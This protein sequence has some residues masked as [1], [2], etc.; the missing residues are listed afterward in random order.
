MRKN[1]EKLMITIAVLTMALEIGTLN[2]GIAA[3]WKLDENADDS[4]GTNHRS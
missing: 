3:H 1:V 4:V 2:A